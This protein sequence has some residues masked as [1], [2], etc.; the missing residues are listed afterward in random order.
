[1]T[2]TRHL[3]EG[4]WSGYRS[5]QERVVHRE[6]TTEPWLIKALLG[7]YRSILYTDGTRLALTIRPLRKGE[8]RPPDLLSYRE[9]IRECALRNIWSVQENLDYETARKQAAS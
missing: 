9:L 7:H 4:T 6:T 2:Q 1:M 5:S 8:R 3:I